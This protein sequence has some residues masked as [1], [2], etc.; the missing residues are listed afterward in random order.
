MKRNDSNDPEPSSSTR[1]PAAFERAAESDGHSPSSRLGD[2]Q[3][4]ASDTSS[5]YSYVSTNSSNFTASD[6]EGPGRIL[7]NL[8]SSAG[9]RLERRLKKMQ[10]AESDRNRPMVASLVN[11]FQQD[12]TTTIYSYTSAFSTNYTT[13]NLPGPGRIIGN[14]YSWAG[15]AFERRLGKIVNRSAL[16]AYSEAKS[17]ILKSGAGPGSIPNMM[18]SD[19]VASTEFACDVLLR[20]ARY[21][22]RS[23]LLAYTVFISSP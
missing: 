11:D 1:A 9:L 3:Q 6:L 21:A 19:D 12:Q 5:L 10:T 14:L 4:D 22:I 8:Y 20:C 23:A 13:S 15:S 7:G 17:L 16:K 18:R 2:F